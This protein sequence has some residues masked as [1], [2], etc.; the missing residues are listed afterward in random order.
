MHIRFS[1]LAGNQ[2]GGLARI[3]HHPFRQRHRRILDRRRHKTVRDRQGFLRDVY[4]DREPRWGIGK[5]GIGYRRDRWG[6]RQ[7]L[8]TREARGDVGAVVDENASFLVH[9]WIGPRS[10]PVDRKRLWT[11]TR[12][13]QR[14]KWLWDYARATPRPLFHGPERAFKGVSLEVMA[15]FRRHAPQCEDVF[16]E[17]Y[18][19]DVVNMLNDPVAV[20]AAHSRLK[21]RMEPCHRKC[22]LIWDTGRGHHIVNGELIDLWA[23]ASPAFDGR[24]DVIDADLRLGWATLPVE[25]GAGALWYSVGIA[26]QAR[27]QGFFQ[28]PRFASRQLA[29]RQFVEGRNE[30]RRVRMRPRLSVGGAIS[31]GEPHIP[32]GETKVRFRRTDRHRI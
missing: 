6:Q 11:H 1:R 8:A 2:P 20:A 13:R 5:T 23:R 9:S 3:D 21:E 26:E 19:W 18:L 24:L 7:M 29:F 28:V 15:R 32:T 16:V 31:I 25:L 12:R 30:R 4:V 22:E 14:Q 10:Q 27:R 17:F